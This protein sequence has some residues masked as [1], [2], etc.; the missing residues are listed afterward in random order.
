MTKKAIAVACALALALFVWSPLMA[1][2]AEDA[3]SDTQTE[4]LAITPDDTG[5]ND[6]DSK[7]GSKGSKN[8]S[9]SSST[10]KT[11]SSSSA[12]PLPRTGDEGSALLPASLVAGPLAL[13]AMGAAMKKIEAGR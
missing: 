11:S 12:S 8:G 7:D 3:A 4:E 6:S 13:L 1:F 5:T 10:S 9:T 2:A